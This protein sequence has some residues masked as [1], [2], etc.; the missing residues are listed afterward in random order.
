M[1]HILSGPDSYTRSQVLENIKGSIGD[2]EAMA[3]NTT[4]LE[5]RQLT[6]DQMRPVCEAMPFLTEKRLVIITSLLQRFEPRKRTSGISRSSRKA[7]PVQDHKPLGEYIP[8]VPD[9]TVIILVDEKISSSNPLFKM[10]SAKAQVQSFPLLGTRELREWLQA[11]IA[12]EG[13]SISSQAASLLIR[14]VGSDLWVMSSEASKLLLYASGRRIEEEDVRLLVGYTQQANIFAMVDAIVEFRAQPAEKMLQSL[15]QQGA[16]P[17]YLLSMLSR[18]MRLIVRAREINNSRIST[19]EL[20]NRLGIANDFAA[21]KTLE[22]ARRYSLLQIRH[23]Y[24]KLLE[25]DVAIKTGKYEP[26]L[27][28]SILVAELCQQ[29]TS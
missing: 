12:Q 15:L 22:Q 6:V 2:T 28:L 26:E 18:Q 9:S 13:G 24:R 10:L 25:T 1:L 14:L 17:G 11:Y 19:S 4:I 8:T 21:R 5:G 23:V 29:H 27:A 20:R 16:A 7:T 3:L